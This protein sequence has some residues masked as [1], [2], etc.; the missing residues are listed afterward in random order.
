[1]GPTSPPLPR[2]PDTITAYSMEDNQLWLRKLNTF[3]LQVFLAIYVFIRAWTT[4]NT[5][6]NVLAIPISISGSVKIGERIWCLRSASYQCFKESLFPEPD[7]G[8]NYARYMEAYMAGSQEGFIVKV[9]SLIESP[10]L[11]HNQTHPAT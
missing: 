8:P 5:A 3:G 10:F 2:R 4:P 11:G 9:E 1:M 6:L 7:P